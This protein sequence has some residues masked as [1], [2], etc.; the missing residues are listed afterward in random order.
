MRPIALERTA[1]WR[2]LGSF[3]HTVVVPVYHALGGYFI[4]DFLVSGPYTWG[5]TLRTLVLLLS[6]LVL[7]YEFVY[8][9]LE[10]AHPDWSR[11]RLMK[12]LRDHSM[13]PFAMGM[14]ALWLLPWAIRV[15]R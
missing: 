15:L 5:R 7:A 11:S 14:L 4:L 6:N 2:R 13:I 10:A 1:G 8:R 12:S 3:F 9:D